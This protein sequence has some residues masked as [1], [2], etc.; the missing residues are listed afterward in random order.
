MEKQPNPGLT[1]VSLVLFCDVLSSHWGMISRAFCRKFGA[2]S[3]A[4]Q[5]SRSKEWCVSA[6]VQVARNFH[7]NMQ[8]IYNATTVE[9]VSLSGAWHPWRWFSI[10]AGLAD[11]PQQE[12]DGRLYCRGVSAASGHMKDMKQAAERRRRWRGFGRIF[13]EIL[14]FL[15]QRFRDGC[16]R[17]VVSLMCCCSQ[18]GRPR[19]SSSRIKMSTIWQ[20]QYSCVPHPQRCFTLYTVF[21]CYIL[22]HMHIH[23]YMCV[24][25]VHSPF[26]L[27]LYN[28]VLLQFRGATTCLN[29]QLSGLWSTTLRLAVPVFP[30]RHEGTKA[31][32]G[33]KKIKKKGRDRKSWKP[34]VPQ[35]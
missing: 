31:T 13:L 20:M 11:C 35:S 9:E 28:Y 12:T 15:I 23:T 32:N 4:H 19:S 33:P 22:Y 17:C 29:H 1:T 18:I 5:K 10:L 7:F 3:L 8:Y 26:L 6:S 27:N 30:L 14:I 21:Y 16:Y 24:V 34:F 2:S 25:L